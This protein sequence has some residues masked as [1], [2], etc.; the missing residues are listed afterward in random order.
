MHVYY[1]NPFDAIKE[2]NL[3]FF[4]NAITRREF[5]AL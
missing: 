2:T 3:C 5:F 4:V 1:Y